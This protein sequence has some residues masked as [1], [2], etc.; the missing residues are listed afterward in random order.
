MMSPALLKSTDRTEG[1][2]H[3]APAPKEEKGNV[4]ICGLLKPHNFLESIYRI[5]EA[6]ELVKKYNEEGKPWMRQP[7]GRT[8]RRNR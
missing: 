1:R 5:N 8:K 4:R 7:Y 6:I 3:T 2:S